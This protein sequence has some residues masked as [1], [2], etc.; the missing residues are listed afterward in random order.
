VT[1]GEERGRDSCCK[2][3]P[4][5]DQRNSIGILE[6]FPS[7][8]PLKFLDYKGALKHLGHAYLLGSS[9]GRGLGT[10]HC[11]SRCAVSLPLLAVP[12]Q[13]KLDCTAAAAAGVVRGRGVQKGYVHCAS[14]VAVYILYLT[15]TSLLG[16]YCSLQVFCPDSCYCLFYPNVQLIIPL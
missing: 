11:P 7:K 8:I 1:A 4:P 6:F 16:I 5:L 15:S 2:L 10:H 14:T 9:A 12:V 3:T 13:C